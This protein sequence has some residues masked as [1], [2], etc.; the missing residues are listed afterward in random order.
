MQRAIVSLVK[1]QPLT[2][3]SVFLCK[4]LIVFIILTYAQLSL[5][6]PSRL[7]SLMLA[8]MQSIGESFGFNIWESARALIYGLGRLNLHNIF[9]LSKVKFY[10][11]LCHSADVFLRDFFRIYFVVSSRIDT[12][13]FSVFYLCARPVQIYTMS[14]PPL[15]IFKLKYNK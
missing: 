11:Q 12:C 13:C 6:N 8:G 10:H 4:S 5:L 7:Q 1:L 14:L 9:K 3:F 15:S 2:S